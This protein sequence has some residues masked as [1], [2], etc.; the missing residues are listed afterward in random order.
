MKTRILTMLAALLLISTGAFAQSSETPLKGDVN[1]DGKVD[2]ADINAIIKIM[3]DAGGTSGETT[4]YWYAGTTLPDSTNINSIATETLTAKPTTW[5]AANPK[6]IAATNNTGSSTYIY[7]CF[8]TDWNVT[9]LDLDKVSE[10]S[11]ADVSTFTYN[12]IP[13]TVQR[14]GRLIPNDITKS[15]YAKCKKN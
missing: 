7:Y 13:Y 6:S 1:E 2:V 14:T 15:Y 8:P 10:V 11:L 4:Y 5:T 12:N 9:V 3:K